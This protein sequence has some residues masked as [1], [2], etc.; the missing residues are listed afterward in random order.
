MIVVGENQEEMTV[1][2]ALGPRSHTTDESSQIPDFVNSQAINARILCQTVAYPLIRSA[3][4]ELF[5]EDDLQTSLELPCADAYVPLGQKLSFG[6]V[7]HLVRQAKNEQTI[8][9]GYQDSKGRI[10][11]LPTHHEER[12]YTDEERLVVFTRKEKDVNMYSEEC[13]C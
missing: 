6:L 2:L 1:K 10:V 9:I 4:A 12:E 3:I 5:H 11:Y 7:Q 8:C 13:C